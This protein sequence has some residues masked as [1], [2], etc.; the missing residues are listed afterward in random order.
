MAMTYSYLLKA[1]VCVEIEKRSFDFVPESERHGSVRNL[2][3]VWFSANMQ[4][5][6]LVAGGIAVTLGLNAIWGIIAAFL[7]NAVGGI[8]MALHSA[9]GPRLGLPQMIQSRAQF[10]NAGAS[11]PLILVII[12]YLGS[13]AAGAILGAQALHNIFP[14]ISMTLGLI[15]LG[16]VT[17]FITLFGHDLIHLVQRYLAV[18]FAVTF[19]LATIAILR[20]D[21][22]TGSFSFAD[23][24]LSTFL[25][26]FSLTTAF[27]L[28]Y[29]PYVA[30]YSRYL[31][32]NIS[33]KKTFGYTYAGSVLSTVWMMSLGILLFIAIP[34]FAENQTYYFAHLFG[35]FFA[36]P[37]YII[38]ILGIIGINVLNLYGAFMS[39]VTNVSSFTNIKSNK[40]TRLW[41]V[42]GTAAL[43]TFLGI[44]GQS[45]LMTFIEIFARFIIY[46]MIPWSTINLIDYYL[47]RHGKYYTEDFFK[48]KEGKY[49]QFNWIGIGAL[50]VSI[51]IEIP[52]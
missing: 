1:G 48:G 40:Q 13:Y 47:V 4:I 45:S 37:M 8:F 27:Q 5:T 42:L 50:L 43:A 7:G 20:L 34:D 16:A 15:I 19:I 35:D 12:L 21:Y 23:F 17:G 24:D 49:G 9:Q 46:V 29:G 39:V 11:L 10:G 14:A 44:M 3:N 2:F 33:S 51:I 6:V 26:A 28:S 22:P 41:I 38:M 30:D 25:M 32:S 31:P 18:V 52:L 36:L